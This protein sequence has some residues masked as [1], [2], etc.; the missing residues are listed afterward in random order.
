MRRLKHV[1][2]VGIAGIGMSGI[3]KALLEL[4][5]QVSGSDL[6]SS[7]V[8]KKLRKMG[9]TIHQGHRQ[10]NVGDPGL[11]VVSS[12]VSPKNSEVV[13]A[14]KKGI[15]VI[16]RAE[17]LAMLM[18]GKKGIAVAGTHGKTTTTSM[19][20][21]ILEKN[22]LDPSVIIGG[23]LNDIGGNAK[24]GRGEHLVVEADESDGSL[25]KLS[26]TIAVVT[27]IEADHLDYHHTLER[28]ILAFKKFIGK[29]PRSGLAVLCKDC[30]N[31]DE[32]ISLSNKRLVTYGIER[33]ADLVAKEIK[34][35]GFSSAFLVFLEGERL[36]EVK[37][38][39]P[40]KHNVSNAL[41]AIAVGL[42][43]GLNFPQI[44]QVLTTFKGVKRRFQIKGNVE[45][46]MVIDDYAHHPTEIETTLS[47]AKSGFNRWT[48]SVFQP[49]RYTRTRDLLEEFGESFHQ[50]DKVVI[51]DIYPALEEPIPGVDAR[52]IAELIK[53]REKGKEV[54]FI[55]SK[56]EIV[57]H[58]LST[59]RRG[60][61]ILT[62]GAGDVWKVSRDFVS[63]L[64]KQRTE[65]RRQR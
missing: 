31:M 10:A 22:N 38:N 43:V 5:C 57:T 16:Q 44:S 3:A 47:A 33:E 37:L 54:K 59:A 50:A 2:F 13:Y 19:V 11:M 29:L 21:L 17:M 1:H 35:S 24:L 39:V 6:N 27:N 40:G 23:E 15:P 32:I 48:T 42:E 52:Q 56:S 30:P 26:P 20:A 51:T 55:S 7:H 61:L 8:T 58:L 60:D 46:I 53:K 4:G 49:H 25:L 18:E 64:K 45:G 9:A 41:A 62:L 12:A 28:I 63:Q 34:L 14:H 65:D 36:G